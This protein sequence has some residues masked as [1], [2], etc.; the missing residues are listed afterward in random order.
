[1]KNLLYNG[2][3]LQIGNENIWLGLIG[4]A[5][6]FLGIFASRINITPEIQK[7]N[8][9]SS[10]VEHEKI[11]FLFSKY[12]EDNENLRQQIKE[13]KIEIKELELYYEEKEREYLEKIK[14]SEDY[15]LEANRL[16]DNLEKTI[17]DLKNQ[18]QK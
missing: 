13:I 3:L 1:M 12:Q 18:S 4:L 10:K 2:I 6:T 15:L 5:S 11:N 14:E 8:L 7:N 9:E 16:I 17:R